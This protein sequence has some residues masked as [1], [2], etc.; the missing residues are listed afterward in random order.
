MLQKGTLVLSNSGATLGV[1][2]ILGIS[3]CANDG[4]AA[5]LGIEKE[6]NPLFAYYF[7]SSMTTV[8][9]EQIAPGLGQPNLNTDLIGKTQLPIPP[10]REQD[11]IASMLQAIDN[12]IEATR[13]VIE[14]TRKLKSALLHNMFTNGT[15]PKPGKRNTHPAIGEFPSHWQLKSMSDVCL[16]IN[17]GVHQSVR[18]AN[19]GVPFLYVSCVRNNRIYWDDAA[20]ISDESYAVISR[21]REPCVGGV[22]YTV[23]G[24]YGH[25]A[26]LHDSRPFSF[27]RHIAYLIPNRSSVLPD[28]ICLWLNSDSGKTYADKVALGNAQKTITLTELAAFPIPIP[29]LHEQSEIVSAI[30]VID[31]FEDSEDRRLN[32]L[33]DAKT[34]LSHGLLNGSIPVEKIRTSANGSI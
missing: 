17:D 12:A 2:K 25:A 7:L 26:M 8:F 10:L 31:G 4:I 1:P 20:K 5:F 29:P 6:L 15:K 9:R 18:T 23:V 16:R 33:L 27:Q 28:F 34:A 14:Q 30:N 22:L 3:G 13:A 11:K 32:S 21:G 24:S 19:S